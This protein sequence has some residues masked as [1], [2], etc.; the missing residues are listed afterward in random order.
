MPSLI[1]PA[2]RDDSE[3]S[4]G[5]NLLIAVD[6]SGDIIRDVSIKPRFGMLFSPK[7]DWLLEMREALMRWTYKNPEHGP[8]PDGRAYFAPQEERS[9]ADIPW[10]MGRYLDLVRLDAQAGRITQRLKQRVKQDFAWIIGIGAASLIA[11]S[12]LVVA[13][14]CAPS[15]DITIQQVV[16]PTPDPRA[17]TPAIVPSPVP[18]QP[19]ETP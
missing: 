11:F 14:Y 13:P 8:R 4:E 5:N 17:P 1:R 10:F 7:N 3:R 12:T 18:A 15:A 16:Q 2:Q 9:P 19:P 6:N